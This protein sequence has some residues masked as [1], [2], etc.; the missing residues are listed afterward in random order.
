VTDA[1]TEDQVVPEAEPTTEATTER[2]LYGIGPVTV[3]EL[4]LV[5]VWL[6]AFIISFFPIFPIDRFLGT[7]A[8]APGISVWTIGIEW[9]LTIGLPTV[10][11]F[12][13]VL[14]RFS[15]D[16]IRRVGSLAIDQFASVAF[17]V[18]AVVWFSMLWQDIAG[19]ISGLGL[20]Y[21][22]VVWVEFFLM[23][24]GVVLTVLAPFI[25]PFAE[26]FQGRTEVPA[27]RNAR[28]VRAVTA[29]PRPERPVAPPTAEPQGAY[30]APS[31]F[32]AAPSGYATGPQPSYD[33]APAYD[34][35]PSAYEPA[36]SAYEPAAEPETAAQPVSDANDTG[37]FSA[38]G[39]DTSAT[40][41]DENW[42]PPYAR[43][44]SEPEAEPQ[45]APA[46]QQSPFW[47]LAPVEREVHD[48]LGAP[49]FTVGPTAWA[50]VI[51]DRGA[52]YV[53]QHEDG[54]IGYLH[55]VSGIRRG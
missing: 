3:R 17:S 19:S 20:S 49:I 16:G 33:A 23:L 6:V 21:S 31:E 11:V 47:A 10:A 45:P 30:T 28:P 51:E 26:D 37:T 41:E 46:A 5:A 12:L 9:V 52:V 39:I 55:D 13:L 34:P 40:Q 1:N 8:V 44:G 38:L 25:P 32:D 27:H 54:R 4:S 43:R 36:P 14:R 48:E 18:S 7:S 29:R 15:P 50:L 53:I 24:A 35:A 2:P 22:W 42:S